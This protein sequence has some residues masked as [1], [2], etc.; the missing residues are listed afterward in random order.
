MLAPGCRSLS[1]SRQSAAPAEQPA[2]APGAHAPQLAATPPAASPNAPTPASTATATP[3]NPNLE[4]DHA[5]DE[6]G[7][8]VAA[9]L[10]YL[11]IV[12]GDPAADEALPLLLV[13]HGLG[14]KPHRDWLHAIDVGR[15]QKVRMVLPQAPTPRGPGFSW[16]EYRFADQHPVELAAGIR[17]AS[18]R[19]AQMI[20]VLSAQRPTRGRALVT[21]FSQGGMLSFAL[22]TR[23]P[24]LIE[25]A[26]PISGTLPDP[27]WPNDK[28]SPPRSPPIHALHGNADA[29]V[30]PASDKALVAKLAQLG[31]PV[32]L[33]TFDGVGH[34]ITPAMS[35]DVQQT[36]TAALSAQSAT[37]ERAGRR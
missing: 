31:Y 30:D 22:A 24:A 11:E 1:D 6:S 20:E 33:R 34:T 2:T 12:R 17:G 16:F 21:G 14:D 9:G 23:H 27:L 4:P 18:D 19:L 28:P 15:E 32:E 13:I 25:Y 3:K 5:P 36:L 26:I 29:I 10:R 8:G 37:L 35:N 7:W